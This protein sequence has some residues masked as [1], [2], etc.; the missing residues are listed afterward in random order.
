MLKGIIVNH[1]CSSWFWFEERIVWSCY[2]VILIDSICSRFMA[3]SKPQCY[4]PI[5]ISKGVD[6]VSVLTFSVSAAN[7][8][9]V[10]VTVPTTAIPLLIA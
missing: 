5:I 2:S 8:R 9:R 1:K 6:A 4:P 3:W 7:T 10:K